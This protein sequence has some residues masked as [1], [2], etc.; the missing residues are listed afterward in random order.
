VCGPLCLHVFECVVFAV[1]V[2][3]GRGEGV[4]E[5]GTRK[6][7]SLGGGVGKGLYVFEWGVW[8]W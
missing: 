7:G 2:N 3:W 8:C 5:Q 1:R 4:G 6:W